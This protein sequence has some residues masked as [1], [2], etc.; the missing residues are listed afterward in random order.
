LPVTRDIDDEFIAYLNRYGYHPIIVAR[1]GLLPP[2]IYQRSR[3]DSFQF[4]C[5]LQDV[6][7][8][9][10]TDL[11]AEAAPAVSF[12]SQLATKKGGQASVGLLAGMLKAVGVHATPQIDAGASSQDGIHIKFGKT[13]IRTVPP[14]R[15]VDALDDLDLKKFERIWRPDKTHIAYEFLYAHEVNVGR[16]DSSKGNVRLGTNVAGVATFRAELDAQKMQGENISY[17]DKKHPVAV[18]FKLGMVTY[19][20]TRYNFEH[21]E[22]S[23]MG[24]LPNE[25]PAPLYIA[26][27]GQVFKLTFGRHV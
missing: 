27:T 20:G 16:G 12:T 21:E 3:D 23:G 18:G 9:N 19:D 2:S 11:K 8:S 26:K 5:Q 22:P 10:S 6:L 4:S 7:L 15:I 24:F 13:E 1:A 17:A 25:G 14:G